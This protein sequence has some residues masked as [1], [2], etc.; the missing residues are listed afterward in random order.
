MSLCVLG[1]T[2]SSSVLVDKSFSR[3]MV[4][5]KTQPGIS[6]PQSR[7]AHREMNRLSCSF[8]QKFRTRICLVYQCSTQG[9]LSTRISII[10]P[11]QSSGH[12]GVCCGAGGGH[13]AEQSQLPTGV[14]LLHC[15]VM[16]TTAALLSRAHREEK[17]VQLHLPMMLLY[18][19]IIKV[20]SPQT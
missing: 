18:S 2:Q 7:A 8:V 9:V 4:F 16:G 12:L 6:Q 1:H 20:T 13:R 11:L 10:L 5:S 19:Y 17:F 15:P 3:S 14:T